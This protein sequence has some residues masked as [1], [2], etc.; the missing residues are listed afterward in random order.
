M[1]PPLIPNTPPGVAPVFELGIGD[2]YDAASNAGRW[3][4]ARWS[5]AGADNEWGGNEP[6]WADIACEV[7]D[8][9]TFTGRDGSIEQFQ[10][11][12]ATLVV[13]NRDGWADYKPPTTADNV[14]NVRPGRQIRVGVSIA[15]AAP[16]WLWRGT[17]D[18]TE[19]GY[20]P[21][22]GDT[23]TLGC[24]DAK[25]D[26]GR[27]EIPRTL[28]PVGAGE[29]GSRRIGRILDNAGWPRARRA[30][31]VDDIDLLE[32]ELGR[33]AA[34]ELDATADSCSAAIYGDLAGRVAYR[35]KSWMAWPSGAPVD[36]TIGNVAAGDIC[37]SGWEVRYG[38]DDL[39]TVVVVG[40]PG[41][42]PLVRTNSEGFA[43]H[44]FEP[45]RRQD[46]TPVDNFELSRIATRV[47]NTRSHKT[48]PRIASVTLHASTGAGEVAQLLATASPFK[49]SRY[50]VRHRSNGRTVFDRTMHVVGVR[51][52]ISPRDGWTARIALDDAIPFRTVASPARWSD[53]NSRWST[54]DQWANIAD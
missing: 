10:V 44:G 12:T 37:P 30:I 6:L 14:L 34:E 43:M 52:T 22:E 49:P 41:Q 24:V 40:R 8:A 1:S 46:L 5:T 20:I 11:G 13:R 33:Q 29:T 32:T 27:A 16:Q 28:V 31:D 54:D 36:A 48:M 19:P 26:A 35:R 25:G 21:G 53:A 3:G 18:T 7:L 9:A 2:R 39:T 51:H 45:W 42:T 23:V 47:L 50:R 15:G 38:R 17:I 4:A